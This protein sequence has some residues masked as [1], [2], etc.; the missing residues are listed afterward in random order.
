MFPALGPDVAARVGACGRTAGGPAIAGRGAGA[1]TVG[2]AA[3]GPDAAVSR[4]S[5]TKER[6]ACLPGCGFVKAIPA[7]YA[8]SGAS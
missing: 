2:A 5:V 3:L 1:P 4:R 6:C 7:R 8:M